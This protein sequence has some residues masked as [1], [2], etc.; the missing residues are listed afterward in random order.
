MPRG[1]TAAEILEAFGA[2]GLAKLTT[3]CNTQELVAFRELVQR[4]EKNPNEWYRAGALPA[5]IRWTH[6]D[7]RYK[8][9]QLRWAATALNEPVEEDEAAAAN[10]TGTSGPKRRG[11]RPITDPAQL[12]RRQQALAKARAARAQKLAEARESEARESEVD[13]ALATVGSQG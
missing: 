7:S 9:S 10:G 8:G 5:L 12:E 1:F 13:R 6:S 2:A 11:R 4:G 3:G